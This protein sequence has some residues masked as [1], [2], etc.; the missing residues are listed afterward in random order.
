[1]EK[2]NEIKN[3]L[4]GTPLE[5]FLISDI[6]TLT[7]DFNGLD[8]AND[9]S[10]KLNE[11]VKYETYCHKIE[12]TFIFPKLT[13][14]LNILQTAKN[15]IET[16]KTIDK[17]NKKLAY[18][19]SNKN[20][21][22]DDLIQKLENKLNAKDEDELITKSSIKEVNFKIALSMLKKND[23]TLYN[24]YLLIFNLFEINKDFLDNDELQG[25]DTLNKLSNFFAVGHATQGQI[26]KSVAIQL[27]ELYKNNTSN[28]SELTNLIGEIIDIYF[29]TKQPYKN[30]TN[31]KTERRYLKNVIHDFNV[32]DISD[33]MND[34]QHDIILNFF[35]NTLVKEMPKF[36]NDDFKLNLSILLENPVTF[37]IDITNLKSFGL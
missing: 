27:Y 1:M 7:M 26:F 12:D 23:S 17:D 4:F 20:A 19:E 22:L 35:E 6:T 37:Y 3:Q 11:F 16:L 18:Y 33:D 30:F 36:D 8:I 13:I 28:I 29:D 2:L 5:R 24:Y 14:A 10:K 34:K 32:F 25:Y 31:F 9:V 21:S 15:A